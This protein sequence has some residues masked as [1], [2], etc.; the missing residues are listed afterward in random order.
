MKN[1]TLGENRE[2]NQNPVKT[3]RENRQRQTATKTRKLKMTSLSE[4]WLYCEKCKKIV[5][6]IEAIPSLELDSTKQ[7]I[8]SKTYT[9]PQCGSKLEK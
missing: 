4:N 9:C 3:N 7:A 8:V 2:T 5:F 6:H 1:Q